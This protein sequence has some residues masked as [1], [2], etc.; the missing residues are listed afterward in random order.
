MVYHTSRRHVGCWLIWVLKA[1][2]KIGLA[3]RADGAAANIWRSMGKCSLYL[4]VTLGYICSAG[5]GDLE[6]GI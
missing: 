1:A 4:K 6:R 2:V 3:S 5:R